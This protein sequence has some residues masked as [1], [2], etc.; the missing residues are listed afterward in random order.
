M[1]SFFLA[2]T[3]KYLYLI[4]DEDNQ[5]S[6]TDYLFTTESHIFNIKT[7]QTQGIRDYINSQNK[8]VNETDEKCVYNYQ[9]IEYICPIPSIY[10]TPSIIKNIEEYMKKS[11]KKKENNN[12]NVGMVD[13]EYSP[14]SV[15]V[16]QRF[17]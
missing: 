4:F 2:E 5:F 17:K 11:E 13:V 14:D 9:S 10:E 7:A 12:N 3:L 1:P 15:F 16:T 8:I 6:S